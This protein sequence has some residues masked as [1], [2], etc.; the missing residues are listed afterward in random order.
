M[1]G[2]DPTASARN[3]RASLAQLAH[4]ARRE[5]WRIGGSLVLTA[6]SVAAAVV[7]P[8]LL[9]RGTDIIFSGVLSQRASAYAPQGM[10]L[11]DAAGIVRRAG[12][13][14]LADLL[15]HAEGTVGAGIAF[16]RLGGVLLIVLAAACVSSVAMWA[17]GQLIR[18]AVHN[19]GAR[20]RSDIQA[21]IDRL[22]LSTLDA[23]PRGDLVSRVT[24]DVDNV[25]QTLQQS[26]SQLFAAA[27]QAI[28][29]GAMMITLS[30][31][32]SVAALT[33]IPVTMIAA[34]LLMR[35]ARPHFGLQWKA[36]GQLSATV[37]EAFTGQEVASLYGAHD[38][39]AHRFAAD[40][41]RLFDASW[42]AQFFSG[43]MN[44]V[45]GALANLS[46]VIVAV[47]GGLL[48]LS[49]GLSL[50]AAQA[51]MQYSRQFTQPLSTLATLANLLQSGAASAERLFDVLALEEMTPDEERQREAEDTSVVFDH[52]A[53]GYTADSPVLRDFS[54]E[55]APG[56]TV[57]IVGATGA[58]KTT[59]VNLLMR[60]YEIDSGAIRLG[61][62]DIRDYSREQLR[63]HFALVLQDTW[64]CEGT[65]REN[66][67]Y[68][69]AC[70][71]DA[72]I[73]A[74]ARASGVDT[75]VATMPAGLDTRVGDDGSPLSAG[76]KQLV[77][78]ARA[79]LADPKILIL[80][81]ATSSVDTRTEI[82]VQQAME[83]LRAGRTSFVIAHRLST[84]RDA[85]VIV[86]LANGDVVEQGSHAELCAR[87]GT[88]ARL[89]QAQFAH[90]EA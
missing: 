8:V 86:V 15:T 31:K 18:T 10:A 22:G 27:L 32:L 42:R 37:E 73:R 71:T 49:G 79:F 62:H 33:I 11:R 24:N 12:H 44:P 64:L 52:V 63:S 85:D 26:L 3:Q 41:T 35:R 57:A 36:T 14:H 23:H 67:A 90:I 29:I 65:V 7:C 45:M 69:K 75:V 77:T 30:W 55:V 17:G 13:P 1:S 54:L 5:G 82:V 25:T 50:G 60:F 43:L 2:V 20:L 16:D 89:W 59:L 9:G 66:I 48:V 51:F 21:K 61:G 6:V 83:R 70:A 56:Q 74:A 53:F 34:R 76:E 58:G 47:I 78:I 87:Q 84:I 46:Y 88:Y 40:N 72:E 4:R 39:F 38:T 19:T 68:G 28:G 81:E 80:D